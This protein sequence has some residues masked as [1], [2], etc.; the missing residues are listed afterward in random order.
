MPS[1]LI[2]ADSEM[3]WIPSSLA[4]EALLALNA[5]AQPPYNAPTAQ[6]AAALAHALARHNP[7]T[8]SAFGPMGDELF[9]ANDPT[10]WSGAA[11]ESQ[12]DR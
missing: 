2:M 7:P 11:T 12:I 8:D 4:A 9:S 5:V 3:L 6:V 1:E 10:A